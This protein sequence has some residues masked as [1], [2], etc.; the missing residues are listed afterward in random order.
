ML[1]IVGL[2]VHIFIEGGFILGV[3]VGLTHTV[4]KMLVCAFLGVGG[5]FFG[6]GVGISS[7]MWN[8]LSMKIVKCTFMKY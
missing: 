6:W 5:F 4:S 7:N 8:K 1:G 3:G 2:W